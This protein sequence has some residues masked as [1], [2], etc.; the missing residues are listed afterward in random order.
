M[1][2]I[3]ELEA[4]ER[5]FLISTK[6]YEK[7][8]AICSEAALH[9]DW[10]NGRFCRNLIEKAILG[11][12]SRNYGNNDG[13]DNGGKNNDWIL[14]AEDFP[15]AIGGNDTKKVPTGFHV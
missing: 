2:K 11:Y 6:A 7:V 3:T 9:P 14:I 1:V 8:I 5:G 13:E 4:K 12:A 10:G 15:S